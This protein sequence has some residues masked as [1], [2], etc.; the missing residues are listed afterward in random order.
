VILR[1]VRPA[2]AVRAADDEIAGWVDEEIG[3]LLRHPALGQCGGDRIGDHLPDHIRGIFFAI[4]SLRIVLRRDHD[5]GAA[6]RLA[7]DILHRHLAFCVWLQ[8]EQLLRAPPLRQDLQDFM[9]EIDRGEH[10][11]PLFVN[12]AFSAC[13]AEHHALVA[14]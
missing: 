8:I 11:R 12:L 4:A 6:D 9:R 3:R 10:E 1:P 13:K 7:I 14:E 2:V 5:L